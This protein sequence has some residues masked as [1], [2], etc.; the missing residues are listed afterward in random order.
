MPVYVIAIEDRSIAAFH[1]DC[2]ADAAGRVRDRLFRG[3]LMAL[4]TGGLPLW[5]GMADIAVRQ[6]H[7]NEESIWRASQAKAIRQGN[8]DG[9]D[10]G[11]VAFL[12]PLSNSARVP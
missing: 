7:S 6:A 8:I 12:V 11:W 2:G 10:D 5:D 3:D 1:A 9:E 4:A